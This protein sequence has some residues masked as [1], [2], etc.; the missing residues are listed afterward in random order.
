MLLADLDAAPESDVLPYFGRSVLR[1]RV[2]PGSVLIAG[3]VLDRAATNQLQSWSSILAAKDLDVLTSDVARTAIAM[4]TY[5]IE[6][7][8]WPGIAV[9][10]VGC[11]SIRKNKA[12]ITFFIVPAV[13]YFLFYSLYIP[14]YRYFL[15]VLVFLCPVV[16]QGVAVLVGW[17][18]QRAVR[19]HPGAP[20][21]LRV[22]VA[23][24]LVLLTFSAAH[25]LDPWGTPVGRAEVRRFLSSL[26]GLAPKNEMV[27]LEQSSRYLGD[28]LLSYADYTHP[29]LWEIPQLVAAGTPCTFFRPINEEAHFPSFLSGRMKPMGI[30]TERILR[31]YGD[32]EP[33]PGPTGD[34]SATV[35]IAGGRFVV[36]R[37]AP[38]TRSESESRVPAE[39]VNEVI[40]IRRDAL[41]RAPAASPA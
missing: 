6:A 19:F 4:K 41:R 32:L 35:H 15:T 5:L 34:G 31:H 29:S 20:A 14:H 1:F 33:M 26:D 2:V 36:M 3:A 18:G 27:F 38:W 17:A 11:W 40:E 22:G 28:T 12:A 23:G 16:G 10:G 37:L 39:G 9:F 24:M 25:R 7:L 8:T 30:H 21:G 13:L